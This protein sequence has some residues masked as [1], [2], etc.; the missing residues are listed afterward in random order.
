M[1]RIFL[2]SQKAED[3]QRLLGDPEKHWRTGYS[4]RTLAHCWED[5]SHLPPEIEN[6]LSPLGKPELLVALPEHKVPLPG[7]SLGEGQNDLFALVRTGENTLALTIEGKVNE[8]FDQ[9][10]NKWLQ[11]ASAGKRQR[12]DFLCDMLGLSQP[13]PDDLHY[14]LLHRTASAIIEAKRFKTDAAAMIVHSFSPERLWFDAFARFA[15][16]FGAQAEVGKLLAV[17]PDAETPVYIG[18]ACGNGAYLER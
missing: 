17:R 5:A 10:L 7:S 14:Q 8:S 18:W 13:L 4:A 6:L 11:N 1:S 15:S 12:L 16:L 3:W 9:P 2:P